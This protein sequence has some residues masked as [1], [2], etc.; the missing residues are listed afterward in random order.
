LD[1]ILFTIPS[2]NE[3]TS[4]AF[5]FSDRLKSFGYALNGIKILLKTEHNARIHLIASILALVLSYLH[6]I[7]KMEW[8]TILFYIDLVFMAELF[9]SSIEYLA[10]FVCKEENKTIGKVKDLTAAGVLVSAFISALIGLI[11][12]T[13]KVLILI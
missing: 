1:V 8:I 12:F 13:P 10:D 5:S 2:N 9:N 4:K 7:S 11:I 6:C 3:K